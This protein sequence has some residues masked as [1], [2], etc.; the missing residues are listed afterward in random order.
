VR[1]GIEAPAEVGVFREEI[2]PA[3]AKR[4]RDREALAVCS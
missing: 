1:L 3:A 2:L 4:Q